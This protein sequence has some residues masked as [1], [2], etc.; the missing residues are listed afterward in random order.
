MIV[1]GLDGSLTAYG[2]AFLALR[3]READDSVLAMGCIRTAPDT[4]SRHVYQADKD[5]A[6][7]DTIADEL[8]SLVRARRPSLIVIEAPA[9]SQHAA[10]AKALGLAYGIGRTVARSVGITALTVQA[11][12]PRRVLCGRRDA[13]KEDIAR[14]C[15]E[16][17][18][19]VAPGVAGLMR[20]GATKP[21]LEG[22]YDAL[23]VAAAAARSPMCE[24]LRS[25]ARSMEL[26]R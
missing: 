18:P 7:V 14:W 10:A 26:P 1:L 12:E 9:G 25:A 16:R 6:R 24:P 2:Y 5:G 15:V 20:E 13:S 23:G 3:A 19:M 22:A 8:L 21:E 17:W 4:K 11:D